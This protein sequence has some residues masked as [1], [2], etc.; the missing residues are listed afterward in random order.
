ML[1]F[2]RF[3]LPG[4][5]EVHP[6]VLA[7]QAQPVIGHRGAEMRGLVEAL[8]PGLKDVFR[9]ERP[10]M[11]SSSSATG[12]MEGAVRG[13]VGRKLLCLVNGAFS[14][15]FAKIA[16]SSGIAHEILEVAWGEAHDP[17]AVA[18]R[19]SVGGFDAVSLV[20]SETSTGALN[21]VRDIVAAVR[22]FPDTLVLV[23][24]VTGIGGAP[25]HTDDWDVDLVLT[26]SQKALALPPGL[27]FGVASP[28]YLQRAASLPGRGMYLDV[29]EF[30][31]QLEKY[32]TPTTPAITLLYALR[33]QLERIADEGMEARWTRHREMS[34][35]TCDW[36]EELGHRLGIDLHVLSPAGARSPTVTCVR[37]PE[38]IDGP[39]VVAGVRERGW[40][41]GGGYGKLKPTSIRIG[42]MG[43]H[44]VSAL[45]AL[46]DV[47]EDV[48][49]R[50]CEA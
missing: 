50:E 32:Q 15:R 20:H 24:S 10:V 33:A 48:I 5:T 18:D 44:S 46:L 26:G 29:V 12:L 30:Y 21:P 8:Q 49:R 1:P 27:A 19:L 47:V 7:A 42:H 14:E 43:D 34:R 28:A 39:T 38:G 17:G 35:R 37:L 11:I 3:F 9:T 25:F 41:I 22:Q 36:V 23:D 16:A 40:V 31:A 6:E 45:E 4:P 13:G 2:G